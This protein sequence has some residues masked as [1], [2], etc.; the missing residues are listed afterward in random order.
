[1]LAFF[2]S[3]DQQWKISLSQNLSEDQ[4]LDEVG[5]MLRPHTLK[6]NN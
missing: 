6:K 4:T 1:M 2:I 5:E 3:P